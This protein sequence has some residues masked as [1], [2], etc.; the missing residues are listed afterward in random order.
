MKTPR[1]LNSPVAAFTLIELLV[2]IAIIAI[3]AGMLLP[4]LATA[5]GKAKGTQCISNMRQITL[6][7]KLYTDEH[8]GVFV[9][10]GKSGTNANNLLPNPSATW[11][12]DVLRNNKYMDSLKI[13]ECPA[14]T[15]FD[16]SISGTNKYA[17][18]MNYPEIGTWLDTAVPSRVREIEVAQPASTVVFADAQDVMNP[19]EPDPD[20]WIPTNTYSQASR[21][22]LC[23]I[24]RDPG[25]P[26]YNTLPD[27][28]VNR[29]NKHC[30]LGFLDG[31]AE[32]GRASTVGYQYIN[33]HPL[34]LW[35]KK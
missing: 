26:D 1:P 30:N 15:T 4:T 19:T 22:W 27:R 7:H 3:L 2:V 16:T 17:I 13:I 6:S 34:A 9:Q 12:P 29:H 28:P 5:R 11:W 32:I 35:D 25:V 24:I 23:I 8:E 10:F 18:G 21:P 14:V 20:K 31:H 33:G